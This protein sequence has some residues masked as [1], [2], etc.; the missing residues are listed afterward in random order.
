MFGELRYDRI[1]ELAI[2]DRRHDLAHV[3]RDDGHTPDA[4][5]R[6]APVGAGG[7]HVV[8]TLLA[9]GGQPF[10]LADRFERTLAKVVALHPDE[11]LFGRAEDGR[12]V[13]TPAM[14]VAVLNFFL[15]QQ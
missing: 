12:V 9:P 1:E 6:D 5:A 14:R 2:R 4:L 11:P 13:T 7:D 15:R 3:E 8:D 10:H